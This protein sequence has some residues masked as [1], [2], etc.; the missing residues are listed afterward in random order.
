MSGFRSAHSHKVNAVQQIEVDIAAQSVTD[1]TM[2]LTK[3]NGNAIDLGSAASAA[4]IP[5][6]VASDQASISVDITADA[7]GLATASNQSTANGHLSTIAGDTTEMALSH[8]AE[9]DAISGSDTGVLI[10]GRNGSNTA[11]P[12]HITN[13][14]DV[15]VEIADFVKGQALMAA[16]FPVVIASDQSAIAVSSTNAAASGSQGNMENNQSVALNDT[17]TVID[18]STANNICIFGSGTGLA[19]TITVEISQDN[20]NFYPIESQIY[21]NNNNAFLQLSNI[22][23]NRIRLKFGG[24]ATAVTMTCQFR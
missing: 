3:V 4:S 23:F 19:D 20:S 5:V 8:Y 11:K 1:L 2:D 17:S 12:I 7:A 21:P 24:S 13:N 6:V 9:G 22:A 18:V 10:M 16:S 14:G 15:E